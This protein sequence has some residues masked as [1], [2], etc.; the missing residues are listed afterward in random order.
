[1][2]TT[3]AVRVARGARARARGRARRRGT[4]GRARRPEARTTRESDD[5]DRGRGIGV[6]DVGERV[7]SV[8][9][10]HGRVRGGV[11]REVLWILGAG[12]RSVRARV[13]DGDGDGDGDGERGAGRFRA[14]EVRE[15]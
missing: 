8:H 2:V 10:T 9:R 14:G 6:G 4:M 3:R 12:V 11:L 7:S 13:D 5:D 15:D 1:M